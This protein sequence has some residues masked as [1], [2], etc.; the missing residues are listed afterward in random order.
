MN[1]YKPFDENTYN[2]IVSFIEQIDKEV[3]ESRNGTF[4]GKHAGTLWHYCTT[5]RGKREKQPCS[6]GSAAGHWRRCYND[7]QKWVNERNTD[8]E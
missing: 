5:I 4:D 7:I 2:Q 6:C 3:R 1:K 8:R